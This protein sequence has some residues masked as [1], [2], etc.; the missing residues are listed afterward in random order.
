[1]PPNG[2]AISFTIPKP[3]TITSTIARITSSDAADPAR[4]AGALG[5]R[6]DAHHPQHQQLTVGRR[7][8]AELLRGDLQVTRAALGQGQRGLRHPPQLQ[9]LLRA[10]GGDRGAEVLARLL[11][12]H[13]LGRAGAEDGLRGGLEAGLL[14]Q[15]LVGAGLQLLHRVHAPT[16][17]RCGLG[18]AWAA[19]PYQSMCA[20]EPEWR[21][22]RRPAGVRAARARDRARR[23]RPGRCRS[24]AFGWNSAASSWTCPR[25]TPS[26]YW[27]PP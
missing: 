8:A 18:G 26:S 9:P 12:V 5:R 20:P 15:L 16:W 13:A 2:S 27:P 17:T 6:D 3:S 4:E 25:P 23:S 14:L 11:G 10:R 19:W 22:D 21:R 7:R 1:M 24:G